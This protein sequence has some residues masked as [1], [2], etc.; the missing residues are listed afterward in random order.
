MGIVNY[1]RNI[2]INLIE[3]NLSKNINFNFLNKTSIGRFIKIN[4]FIGFFQNLK[5]ARK[6]N[7]FIVPIDNGLKNNK[8]YIKIKI[9][10]NA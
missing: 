6:I 3:F 5:N 9:D 1:I 10:F 7:E 2:D 4:K 8:D